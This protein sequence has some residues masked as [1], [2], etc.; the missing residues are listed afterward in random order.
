M[1]E[2]T[3]STNDYNFDDSALARAKRTVAEL[4]KRL[5]EMA[6]FDELEGRYIESGSTVVVEP[7]RDVIKE[8]D[9]EFGTPVNDSGAKTT[10]KSL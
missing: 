1:I 5:D 8:I 4:D 3:R 7:G 2:A 6:R 9:A 10:D